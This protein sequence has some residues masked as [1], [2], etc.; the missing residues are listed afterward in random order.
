[1]ELFS[2]LNTFENS[3]YSLE[4]FM[5]WGEKVKKD[6]NYFCKNMLKIAELFRTIFCAKTF[7]LCFKNYELYFSSLDKK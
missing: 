3:D 2:D 5:V 7:H 1:M 4:L 6:K